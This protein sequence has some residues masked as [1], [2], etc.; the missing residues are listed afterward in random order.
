MLFLGAVLVVAFAAIYVLWLHCFQGTPG[1]GEI[2]GASIGGLGDGGDAGT[3]GLASIRYDRVRTNEQEEDELYEDDES[4]DSG[5][6]HGDLL[7]VSATQIIAPM[8]R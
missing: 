3:A 7:S 8:D 6:D 1:M 4:V 5:D 2:G